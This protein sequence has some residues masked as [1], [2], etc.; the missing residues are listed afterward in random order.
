MLQTPTSM[1]LSSLM[2][3]AHSFPQPNVFIPE[4]WLETNPDYK[5][6]MH[7]FVAFHRGHRNCIGIK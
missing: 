2:M 7:Y 1:T 3:D 6:N 4:R 5:R